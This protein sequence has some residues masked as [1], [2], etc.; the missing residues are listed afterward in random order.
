MIQEYRG[1]KMGQKVHMKVDTTGGLPDGG[2]VTFPAGSP[3]VI[4]A[5]R[6]FGGRQGIG[7]DVVI[8]SHDPEQTIVNTFDDGDGDPNQF[9]QA[10]PDLPKQDDDE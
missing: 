9:F 3:A 5:I 8:W 6:D 2:E 7:F 1:F 10:A 4:D